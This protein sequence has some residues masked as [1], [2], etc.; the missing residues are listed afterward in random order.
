[1]KQEVSIESNQ[2]FHHLGIVSAMIDEIGMV[3]IIDSMIPSDS[4]NKLTT[5]EAVMAMVING[6]GFTGRAM[7]MAPEFFRNRPVGMLIKE[8]ISFEE[9]N[10]DVLGRAL[11]AIHNANSTLIFSRIAYRAAKYFNINT[12]VLHHDT[13]SKILFGEYDSKGEREPS[14]ELRLL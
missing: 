4:R 5:G 3:G 13:S 2:S 7:Y 10:D 9:I 11:D 6:L 8:G 1:M 12:R 14:C